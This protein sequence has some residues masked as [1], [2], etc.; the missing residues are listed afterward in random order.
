M[1]AQAV[2]VLPWAKAKW[3]RGCPPHEPGTCPRWRVIV[4]AGAARSLF[5]LGEGRQGLL[6]KDHP[7]QTESRRRRHCPESEGGWGWTHGR[8][9]SALLGTFL[10]SNFWRTKKQDPKTI[11]AQEDSPISLVQQTFTDDPVHPWRLS[12]Q[13]IR[14]QGGRP[15]LGWS[16]REGNSYPLQYSGLENSMDCIVHGVAE[17]NT[18]EQLSLCAFQTLGWGGR[19]QRRGWEDE[20]SPGEASCA[21]IEI[22]LDTHRNRKGPRLPIYTTSIT[23]ISKINLWEVWIYR[24]LSA[25]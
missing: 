1:W 19:A 16:S 13:R 22:A 14:L 23:K 6:E 21:R 20:F 2:K 3:I 4:P 15:G 11:R 25:L 10:S 7:T 9:S 18:T 5:P 24:W 17:S 8:D 12:W